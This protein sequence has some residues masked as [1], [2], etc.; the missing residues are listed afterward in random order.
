MATQSSMVIPALASCLAVTGPSAAEDPQPI[1]PLLWF[2]AWPTVFGVDLLSL[3][4]C[5][6]ASPTLGLIFTR[7]DALGVD[8]P[9]LASFCY[10]VVIL[11][12]VFRNINRLGFLLLLLF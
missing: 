1:L 4:S 5:D 7:P 11:L 6:F 10:L 3:A 9:R 2:N 12:L 8:V